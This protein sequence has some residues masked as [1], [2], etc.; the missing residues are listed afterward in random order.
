MV[1]VYVTLIVNGRRTY[2]SVPMILKADVKADLEAMG[3]T[4][5]DAGDVKTASAE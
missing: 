3:F 2:N 1:V 5:D 4:V